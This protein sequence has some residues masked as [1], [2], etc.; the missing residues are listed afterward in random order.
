[1]G[2]SKLEVSQVYLCHSPENTQSELHPLLP[3]SIFI[4]LN[5]RGFGY[6]AQQILAV[7][8]ALLVMGKPPDATASVV[9]KCCF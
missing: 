9:R 6:P 4:G 1:M 2:R 3:L 8:C 5:S 7:V